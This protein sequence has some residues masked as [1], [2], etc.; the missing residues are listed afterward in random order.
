MK[1]TVEKEVTDCRDCPMATE[2]YGQGECWTQCSH[3]DRKTTAYGNI[4]WG[5]QQQFQAVPAWCP[6]KEKNT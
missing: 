1:I 2:H 6:A 3:P 5:A 4:L